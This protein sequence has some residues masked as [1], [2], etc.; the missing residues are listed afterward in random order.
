MVL[1]VFHLFLTVPLV[2]LYEGTLKSNL[3]V[4]SVC[5][6]VHKCFKTLPEF[7]SDLFLII[8]FSDSHDQYI[9]IYNKEKDKVTSHN[10]KIIDLVTFI[11]ISYIS[12]HEISDEILKEQPVVIDKPR[13]EDA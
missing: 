8:S 4:D 2:H 10:E 9:C 1:M 6:D 11:I 7:N 3:M 12:T 5:K 13:F